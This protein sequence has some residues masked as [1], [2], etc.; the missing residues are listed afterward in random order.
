VKKGRARVLSQLSQGYSGADIE[1]I[2]LAARR[3]A[4]TNDVQLPEPEIVLT[5]VKSREAGSRFHGLQALK[6]G[7]KGKLARGAFGGR[8]IQGGNRKDSP[9]GT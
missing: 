5:L 7:D 1:N 2:A 6:K 9:L 3:H 4:L 8:N